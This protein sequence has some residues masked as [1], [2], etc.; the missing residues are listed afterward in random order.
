MAD[1]RTEAS[2]TERT[3]IVRVTQNMPYAMWPEIITPLEVSVI[4]GVHVKSVRRCI[5]SGRLQAFRIGSRFYLNK[6]WLLEFQESQRVK[7]K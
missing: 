1:E 2:K 5:V 7:T 6:K 3:D 4:L